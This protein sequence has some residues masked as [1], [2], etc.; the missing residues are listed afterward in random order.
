M[1]R[2]RTGIIGICGFGGMGLS[3]AAVDKRIKAV[4]TTSLYDMSR[5]M[6]RG[7]HDRMTRE[8]RTKVLEQM[9]MQRWADAEK[10]APAA[11]PRV[12]PE[13]LDGIT[14]PVLRMYF[15]YYR[16]PRG[17]HPRSLGSNGAWTAIGAFGF[18]SLPLPIRR[19]CWSS[20]V[21]ST[22]T[23]TTARRSFCTDAAPMARRLLSRRVR[24]PTTTCTRCCGPLSPGSRRGSR[25]GA[26]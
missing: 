24:Q 9:S 18:M 4:V 1:D 12:L 2:E 8:E 6:A 19:S 3:A 26:C 15:D 21:P 7:Y 22:P 16:T 23:C 10:G 11:G 14:D 17:F 5:V 13:T 20:P 25:T